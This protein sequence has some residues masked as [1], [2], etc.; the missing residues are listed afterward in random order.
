[1]TNTATPPTYLSGALAP[2]ATEHTALDLRVTGNLPP[3]LDGRYF[4][5][6]PNPLPGTDPGHWFTGQGM[7]HGVRLSNGRAEWYR[8]R[9]VRTPRFAGED[10]PYVRADGSVDLAAVN[11]NTHVIPH[12][13]RILALVESGFPYELTPELET[14][15][16]CDFGGRLTTAMT[17]HPKEDPA[18]GELHFFG[19]AMRP[20]FL[21]Y[22]VLSA[23]GELVRSVPVDVLGPSMMHDFAI[24]ANHVLWLDL[25]M[26]LDLEAAGGL[27]FRWNDDYPARIGV[28]PRNGNSADVRWIEIDPCYV[29]HVANAAENPDGTITFDAVR[30]TPAT[31]QR[32]W[33][34]I[35]GHA[36]LT[37]AQ[38]SAPTSLHRWVL[39]PVRGTAREQALGDE[40]VEFPTIN[41]GLT[42]LAHR[43]VYT[44]GAQLTGGGRGIVKYDLRD[45]STDQHELAETWQPGEAVFVP[46]GHGESEDA[47]WLLSVTSSETGAAA[48]LLV[49]DATDLAAGPV[50]TVHLPH[51]VPAGF[52][53]SWITD[54][55][56]AG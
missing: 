8:N 48:D 31:I 51:R 33:R 52:H 15:G 24:T 6:G 25:P 42:G 40:S 5:N 12:A 34:R 10:R 20:P 46:S 50:A 11:A 7:V 16:P 43:F 17:A 22:H 36:D 26:T 44:V 2:V 27:P 29:F 3:E 56:L 13:G 35:G 4:R 49:L 45:G 1:M 38:T 54:A 23:A 37:E 39:D 30:Y 55:E 32:A 19:V 41:E 14:V 47:G 9:W 18:T 28:M 53:G 21:T